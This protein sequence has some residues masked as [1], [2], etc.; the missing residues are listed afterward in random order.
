[1]YET[2]NLENINKQTKKTK[3]GTERETKSS[4][5][6]MIHTLGDAHARQFR[7]SPV[8]TRKAGFPWKYPGLQTHPMPGEIKRRERPSRNV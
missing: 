1:M 5:R 7:G 2:Y 8:S 4:T 3:K 6:R